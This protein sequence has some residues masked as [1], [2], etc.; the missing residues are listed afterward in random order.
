MRPPIEMLPCIREPL[1]WELKPLDT[2]ML[3]YTEALL[4]EL[5]LAATSSS[6]NS[7]VI[8]LSGF[9]FT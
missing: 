8:V 3:P 2:P 4:H 5:R 9:M 1:P 7:R 6:N